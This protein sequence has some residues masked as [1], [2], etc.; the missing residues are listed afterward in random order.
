MNK[1]FRK[2]ALTGLLAAAMAATSLGSSAKAAASIPVEQTT[3]DLDQNKKLERT[4][5]DYDRIVEA[6]LNRKNILFDCN[7]NKNLI[8]LGYRV[9][10]YIE[11]YACQNNIALTPY[12]TVD[13][14]IK[15]LEGNAD[16]NFEKEIAIFYQLI[17]AKYQND[18]E[19]DKAIEQ[20]M[21]DYIPHYAELVAH[22]YYTLLVLRQAIR[23]ELADYVEDTFEGKYGIDEH[24]LVEAKYVPDNEINKLEVHYKD[25]VITAD[26]TAPNDGNPMADE[27][28]EEDKK[29]TI[30]GEEKYVGD[31]WAD[32]NETYEELDDNATIYIGYSNG[33][34]KEED[35]MA[36]YDGVIPVKSVDKVFVNPNNNEEQQVYEVTSSKKVYRLALE[37]LHDL[38]RLSPTYAIDMPKAIE[39]LG[40]AVIVNQYGFEHFITNEFVKTGVILKD[41]TEETRPLKTKKETI[42]DGT[43][44]TVPQD[45]VFDVDMTFKK[46]PRNFYEEIIKGNPD[47][48]LQPVII[49]DEIYYE[50]PDVMT[51]KMGQ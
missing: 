28:N 21:K 25:Y 49:G 50:A 20:F 10:H 11:A 8:L 12:T 6:Y 37:A 22:N 3:E 45:S 34:T 24:D 9:Q 47:L 44:I 35:V 27:P 38:Y 36:F 48:L 13:E 42:E 15:A 2:V 46:P 41:G 19:R 4:K 1:D 18:E 14:V 5:K 31:G 29:M 43:I 40:D 39:R 51:K 30:D 23:L 7:S 26:L 32:I 16:Y 33:Q 17:N